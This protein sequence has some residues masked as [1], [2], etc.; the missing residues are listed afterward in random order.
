MLMSTTT[1][2]VVSK[3]KVSPFLWTLAGNPTFVSGLVAWALAQSLKVFLNFFV[4]RRWDFAMLFNSGGMPSSHSALCMALTS[5][6]AL[7]HGVSD[8]LFPVCLGFSL[9][10]MYDAIG[11]RRHAGMQAEVLNKIID[12]LFQGHPISQRKLK[13]LLGHTPS[14]VIAGALLGILVACF[15]C[16]G[17]VP[18]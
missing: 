18:I 8:S 12:D 16:Q 3:S 7:C 2:A 11:V 14:Q 15:C 9:I 13:E 17:I 6:V 4:E 5:S 1:A 10:V